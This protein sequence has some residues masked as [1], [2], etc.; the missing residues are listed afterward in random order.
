[1]LSSFWRRKN[2][3][4]VKRLNNAVETA[5]RLN[6]VYNAPKPPRVEID[7]SYVDRL[8]PPPLASSHQYHQEEPETAPPGLPGD[9]ASELHN[10]VENINGTP[11]H[12][13]VQPGNLGAKNEGNSQYDDTDNLAMRDAS[14]IGQDIDLIKMAVEQLELAE[15]HEA[16]AWRKVEVLQK[17]IR[18]LEATLEKEQTAREDAEQ[19]AL[20][21][22]KQL[23]ATTQ[24]LTALRNSAQSTTSGDN[25]TQVHA[26]LETKLMLEQAARKE[27]EGLRDK[28]RKELNDANDEIAALRKKG[29][30]QEAEIQKAAEARESAARDEIST[31]RTQLT[32]LGTAYANAKTATAS[33]EADRDAAQAATKEAVANRDTAQEKYEN[34]AEQITAL[35]TAAEESADAKETAKKATAGEAEARNQVEVLENRIAE[36][37]AQHTKLEE[38]RDSAAKASE[39]T[40]RA[41][42]ASL[43]TKVAELEQSLQA[44]AEQHNAERTTANNAAAE[45]AKEIAALRLAA[46]GLAAE[47]AR[48]NSEISENAERVATAN[49]EVDL[50]RTRVSELEIALSANETALAD[51]VEREKQAVIRIAEQSEP[52]TAA[53]ESEMEELQSLRSR[54]DELEASVTAAEAAIAQ[55]E[56]TRLNAEFERDT[57]T[58]TIE[59]LTIELANLRDQ[60]SRDSSHGYD[61]QKLIPGY[62][63]LTPDE[64][65]QSIDLN[66]DSVHANAAETTSE[67]ARPSSAP[68]F[69]APA[70][71]ITPDDDDTASHLDRE[72]RIKSNM[73]VTLWREDLGQP[74]NC[75][76]IDKSSRGARLR[77]PPDRILGEEN[78]VSIGDRLTLTFY[79]PRER[80]SVFC[81]IKWI[82]GDYCGVQYYGQFHTELNSP[83]NNS[84]RKRFG[85][86]G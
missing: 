80:T 50:L 83:R 84:P 72:K 55:A 75:T 73:A 7:T 47:R 39:E 78:R 45:A 33:A 27:A 28:A 5:E 56:A 18:E 19:R 41:E 59:Q 21:A 67:P 17:L 9:A 77:I 12:Y 37:E 22:A 34:A 3:R 53:F 76:V 6:E 58:E 32:E 63:E 57:A 38:E 42:V 31:L 60:A 68:S 24:Q 14:A 40:A 10:V 66:A 71:P 48:A 52:D 15:Q 62:V 46:E 13:Q 25:D 82:D 65:D 74:I 23:S 36:L 44:S 2:A 61:D 35:Q 11:Q 79:Y 69:D 54:V 85:E 81:D 29:E 16:E 49:K 20:T 43:E 64:P 30:T 8:Q 4:L 86:A 1:M 26:R 51:A 70:K